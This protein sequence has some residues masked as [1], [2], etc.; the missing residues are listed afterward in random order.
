MVPSPNKAEAMTVGARALVAACESIV[1]GHGN[2]DP[3]PSA[4]SCS[5]DPA[6]VN[7]GSATEGAVCND[8]EPA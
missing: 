1:I 3:S 7:Y 6:L 4:M 2:L 8:V 5:H